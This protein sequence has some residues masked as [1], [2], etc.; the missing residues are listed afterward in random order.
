MLYCKEQQ[1]WLPVT[2]SLRYNGRR[3]RHG[4]FE[5]RPPEIPRVPLASEYHIAWVFPSGAVIPTNPPYQVRINIVSDMRRSE[6]MGRRLRYWYA[7]QA[8]HQEAEAPP[9]DPAAGSYEASGFDEE[10][11]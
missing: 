10:E 2:G 3:P 1:S 8:R 9:D 5:L 4:Y 6:E 11:E 7:M